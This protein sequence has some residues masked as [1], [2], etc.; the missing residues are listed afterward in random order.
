M[1]DK[2]ERQIQRVFANLQ[3]EYPNLTYEQVKE[4]FNKM[5][6]FQYNQKM[7]DQGYNYVLTDTDTDK[8]GKILPLY[9]KNLNDVGS[10]QRDFPNVKFD[11][12]K[13]D[14]DWDVATL[15]KLWKNNTNAVVDALEESHPG[16]T[17]IFI[18]Q[19]I[20]DGHLTVP[21]VNTVANLLIE[22]RMKDFAFPY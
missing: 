18:A 3:I 10:L 20:A 14:L 6:Q 5:D 17:A 11:I 19:G 8:E 13:I 15:F 21:D 7:A 22:R 2:D 1:N 16:L 4:R 12:V 9:A